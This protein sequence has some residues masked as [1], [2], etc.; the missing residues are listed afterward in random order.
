MSKKK[1]TE[2]YGIVERSW[3]PMVFTH[4]SEKAEYIVDLLS[5]GIEQAHSMMSFFSHR[6][7]DYTIEDEDASHG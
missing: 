2:L 4:E 6:E 7:D 3:T 1:G 5:E